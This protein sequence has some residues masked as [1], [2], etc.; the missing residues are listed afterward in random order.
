MNKPV[1]IEHERR[2][3]EREPSAIGGQTKP[4]PSV[5]PACT[6]CPTRA[7]QRS[8]PKCFHSCCG[9]AALRCGPVSRGSAGR[10]GGQ[11]H[12]FAMAAARTSK[13]PHGGV[14]PSLSGGGAS[15]ATDAVAPEPNSQ[16][17]LDSGTSGH[18]ALEARAHLVIEG[19]RWRASD[20]RIPE[21]LRAALVTE[22]MSAR[23][24]VRAAKNLG[25]EAMRAARARVQDAKVAL[26]E[27]GPSWWGPT[28]E[29]PTRVRIA[30]CI[31][32]LSR[33]RGENKSLCPSE[34]ARAQGLEDWRKWMWLV[35]EIAFEL[36]DAGELRVTQKGRDV[37]VDARG[38]IRLQ[39][40]DASP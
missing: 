39:L 18:G 21:L 10:P 5:A 37:D 20:P 31:R 3:S 24:A 35:R 15:K 9:A 6:R 26:G 14:R 19:R 12:T 8:Y 33:A 17:G 36:R 4:K 22:L 27:R 7:R 11:R 38:A 23:R 28:A 30:A 2:Y 34:V 13:R 25:P 29:H 1:P 16:P 32:A 40:V